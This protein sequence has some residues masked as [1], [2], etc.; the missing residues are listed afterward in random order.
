MDYSFPFSKCD[1]LITINTVLSQLVTFQ[2][3]C[4][5][6]SYIDVAWDPV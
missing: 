5:I 3:L 4:T 1:V 2:I 6:W